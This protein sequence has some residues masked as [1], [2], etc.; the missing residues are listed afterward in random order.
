MSE[1]ASLVKKLEQNPKAAFEVSRERVRKQ[2]ERLSMTPTSPQKLKKVTV[3]KPSAKKEKV[4]REKEL[5]L[6]RRP[7]DRGFVHH[8]PSCVSSP[9]RRPRLASLTP[10]SYY[11]FSIGL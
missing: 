1:V 7:G 10:S 4:N 8:D 2:V 11:S 9:R 6:V 5:D 3:E